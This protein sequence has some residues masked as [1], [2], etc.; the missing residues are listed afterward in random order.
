MEMAICVP[1]KLH[2]DQ[3]QPMKQSHSRTKAKNKLMYLENYI[4]FLRSR[5]LQRLTCDQLKQ[6]AVEEGVAMIKPI[7]PA[8]STLNDSISSQ[9]ITNLDEAI[10]DLA[11]LNWQECSVTSIK[12]INS[13]NYVSAV[14]VPHTAATRSTTPKANQ[15][16]ATTSLN[17]SGGPCK[18][19]A[20]ESGSSLSMA[21]EGSGNGGKRLLSLKRKRRNLKNLHTTEANAGDTLN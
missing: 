2:H 1:Q 5:D 10:K 4:A 12:S 19:V 3:E 18:S 17:S 16:I 8:R 14:P 20:D 13:Q 15:T 9:A 21:V 6:K 7:D 11:A